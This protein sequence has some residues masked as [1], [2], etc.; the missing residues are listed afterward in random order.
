MSKGLTLGQIGANG[1]SVMSFAASTIRAYSKLSVQLHQA[2]CLTFYQ[3]AQYGNC[4]ALNVFYAGL[5]VNDAT[6]LRVWIGSHS[7]YIN[8]DDGSVKNWIKWNSK[9]GFSM[10]KGVEQFRKDMFTVDEET[11]G[12]T[13]L[14]AL[15]PFYDKD[16]KDP[17]AFTLE[18]LLTM[19]AGA[20]KRAAKKATD[21]GI[22]L[23]ASVT[24]LINEIDRETSTELAALKRVVAE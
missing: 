20:G 24:A 12:R 4:D 3:A 19:L 10:V 15:K 6:A 21:E 9:D 13:M 23:P 5:R 8:L 2:A 18:E 22:E 7:S 14:L 16:I 11:A 1:K 17:K